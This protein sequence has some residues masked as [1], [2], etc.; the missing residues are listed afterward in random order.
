QKP[1]ETGER[2]RKKIAASAGIAEP[3]PDYIT[4]Q[5]L[6]RAASSSPGLRRRPS[7]MAGTLSLSSPE[8]ALDRTSPSH[9]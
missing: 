8:A 3:P 9:S 6:H 5:Y 7:L 2:K 1:N 4:A